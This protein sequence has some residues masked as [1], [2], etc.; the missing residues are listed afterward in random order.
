ML[1]WIAIQ[2]CVDILTR[3]VGIN[4]AQPGPYQ[5]PWLL[6]FWSLPGLAL[7]LGDK[8][9]FENYLAK[10]CETS[11]IVVSR[12]NNSRGAQA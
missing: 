6:L 2:L 3:T 9:L 4:E 12:P 8:V 11:L 1:V 5:N 7:W 10:R